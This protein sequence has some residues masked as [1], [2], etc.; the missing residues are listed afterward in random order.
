MSDP[1]AFPYETHLDVRYGPLEDI[2]IP[3]LVAACTVP[4][5]NQTLCR[6]N[7][8]VVRLGVVHGEYH[9]HKHDTEDEYFYVVSGRFLIDLRDRT[10]D[11]LPGHG[12]VVPKG[13]EHRPR[14][15]ERTI[16][17]MVEGAG[18]V[19]TGNGPGLRPSRPMV[20]AGGGPSDRWVQAMQGGAP[21]AVTD[22]DVHAE[23]VSIPAE[24]LTLPL[25]RIRSVRLVGWWRPR[26]EFTANDVRALASVPSE[27]GGR[28]HLWI[29][30]KDRGP[31]ARLVEA[32]RRAARG[33]SLRNPREPA[34][35][36]PVTTPRVGAV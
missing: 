6:V 10:I 13:I 14:A 16:I 18:I 23:A 15:P 9:W 17:L 34:I 29:A 33:R 5:Y 4:W 27:E 3:G 25:S 26:L 22:L 20:R 30:R 31:A 19:P 12:C 28:V 2:D 32:M 1:R 24:Q 21:D 35:L 11:L 36:P 8:C 7:D